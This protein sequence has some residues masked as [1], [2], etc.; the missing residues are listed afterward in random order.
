MPFCEGEG[1]ALFYV[2]GAKRPLTRSEGEALFFSLWFCLSLQRGFMLYCK[3]RLKR[4]SLFV[5]LS[6]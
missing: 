3:I 5:V 6:V 4:L 2:C 1:E